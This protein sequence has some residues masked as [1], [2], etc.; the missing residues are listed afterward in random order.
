MRLLGTL[1]R[2]VSLLTALVWL[3]VTVACTTPI[4]QATSVPSPSPS[5]PP[6]SATPSPAPTPTPTLTPSPT[7]TPKPTLA[8]QAITA[9]TAAQVQAALILDEH[10]G[11]IWGVDVTA[12]GG[13]I[14]S[15]STDHLVR[16]FDGRSGALLHVLEHHR[17]TVYCV[18]FSPDG[19]RLV[20]GGRD[21]TVQIWDVA[22][23]E[24]LNGQRATGEVAQVAFSPDGT[25]FAGVGFFSAIGEVWLA[26]GGPLFTLEGHR[27]RLRSVAWSPDGRWIA[28][29]NSEGGIILNDPETGQAARVLGAVQG[30]ANALAFS[31]D[32][33][34]LAVGT[35]RGVVALW[36]LT[37]GQIVA[38]WGAHQGGVLDLAYSPDGSLLIT[39]GGDGVVRLW[40]AQALIGVF[41][42]GAT[43]HR[44]ATLAGHGEAVRGVAISAD[45]STLVSGG[46]D[47]RVFV[48]R[49]AP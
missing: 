9:Q 28:S 11:A 6:P 41:G 29:G 46:G 19:T 26:D 37:T 15:A 42:S 45:G 22:S 30:D 49:I 14:A 18:A 33:A 2:C 38:S 16:L 34:I 44:L 35:A 31:P 13:L 12:D 17:D 3:I 7:P 36:D 25:R 20:S 27:T 21:R 10:Y 32:G 1:C 23:G 40:D 5:P 24:R 39:S 4:P 47:A 48:W 8:P 43:A